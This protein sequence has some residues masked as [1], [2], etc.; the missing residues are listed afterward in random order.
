[1]FASVDLKFSEFVRG[2]FEDFLEAECLVGDI[3]TNRHKAKRN[4]CKNTKQEH[5]LD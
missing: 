4:M 2:R 5:K 3:Y 1:M